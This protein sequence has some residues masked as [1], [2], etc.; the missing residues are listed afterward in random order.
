MEFCVLL[1]TK[2]NEFKVLKKLAESNIYIYI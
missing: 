1:S 2:K